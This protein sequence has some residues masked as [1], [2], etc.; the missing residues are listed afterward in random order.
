MNDSQPITVVVEFE[1]DTDAVSVDEWLDVW[2]DRADDAYDHEPET[3]AYE[4][5]VNVEE[6]SRVLVFERYSNGPAGLQTHMERPSHRTIG[7]AMGARRMNKQRTFANVAVDIPDY[8]WWERPEFAS[9]AR[10][11]DCPFIFLQM[12]FADEA[13]RERFIALSAEHARYCLDAEPGT[14]VYSGAIAG[15]DHESHSTLASGDLL[16]VMV[17]K[18]DAAVEK[19][20]ADPNHVAL[21]EKFAA[22]GIEIASTVVVPYRTTGRGFLWR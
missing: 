16:F 13:S 20:A 7:E 21:G 12:R 5:A 2:E 10:L 9:P 3:T 15:E 11:D 17:C 6:P 19:H 8:G 18:D 14:L 4:A 1:V 22:E